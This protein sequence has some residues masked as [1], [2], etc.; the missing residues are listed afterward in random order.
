MKIWQIWAISST[1]N[2]W[3][4]VQNHIFQV[5]NWQNFVNKMITTSSHGF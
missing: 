4:M 1:K 2:P 3:C 5:E